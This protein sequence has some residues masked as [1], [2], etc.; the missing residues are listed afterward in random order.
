MILSI[1]LKATFF[2]PIEDHKLAF[3]LKKKKKHFDAL[4]FQDFISIPWKIIDPIKN[5]SLTLPHSPYIF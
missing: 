3:A 5:N 4:M 2:D 1:H